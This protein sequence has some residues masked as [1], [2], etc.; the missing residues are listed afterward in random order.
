[1][2]HVEHGTIQH[3]PAFRCCVNS[4]KGQAQEPPAGRQTT[5]CSRQHSSAKRVRAK[6]P[7]LLLS[8]HN[9]AKTRLTL[10][11]LTHSLI[12]RPSSI[13]PPAFSPDVVVHISLRSRRRPARADT[14]LCSFFL[15][16]P[17]SLSHVRQVTWSIYRSGQTPRLAS[18]QYRASPSS[19][20]LHTHL[21]IAGR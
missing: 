12:T 8:I 4:E 17:S 2:P 21:R 20:P 16:G 15:L 6:N 7:A 14:R 10:V 18:R 9:S 1:M 5:A 13:S 11:S 3:E 19:L